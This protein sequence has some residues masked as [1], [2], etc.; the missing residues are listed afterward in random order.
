MLSTFPDRDWE[1]PNFPRSQSDW[2]NTAVSLAAAS[3]GQSPTMPAR[4]RAQQ[5][6]PAT[7]QDQLSPCHILCS[8]FS[9]KKRRWRDK[10]PP[11]V[12]HLCLKMIQAHLSN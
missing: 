12:I 10:H 6:P 3:K 4:S 2:S 1:V 9:G 11:Q 8:S 7:L 5:H